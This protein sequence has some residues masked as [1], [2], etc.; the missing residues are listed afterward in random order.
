[1][2][3]SSAV[4]LQSDHDAAQ[5]LISE[6]KLPFRSVH[7]TMSVDEM[8]VAISKHRAGVVVVDIEVASIADIRQLC[9]EFPEVRIVCTHRVADEAMWIA[10]LEAGAAD[11]CP[12]TD[13]HGILTA[14][15]AK[16]A[17]A[18]AAAA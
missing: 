7:V 14:V 5:S 15:L 3:P 4:I 13:P 12:S 9:R 16:A 18:H 10:A 11:L 2:K 8:R 17:V 6:L 1:M